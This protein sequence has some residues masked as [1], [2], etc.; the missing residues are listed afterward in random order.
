MKKTYIAPITSSY[1][2]KVETLIAISGP[3]TKEGVAGEVDVLSR[4]EDNAIS[5]IWD[6]E[7]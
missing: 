4:E 5:N 1:V 6:S 3:Q 2:V 7:W